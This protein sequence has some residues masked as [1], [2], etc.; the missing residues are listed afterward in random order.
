[1]ESDLPWFHAAVRQRLAADV[2]FMESCQQRLTE[3][4][5]Q[6]S[7]VTIPYAT[8][9]FPAS[10]G[11]MGGGGYTP[12]VQVD[13]WCPD[14]GYGNEEA[15]VVVWRIASRAKRV[16]EHAQNVSFQTMHWSAK[17]IDLMPLPKDVSRGDANPLV[18][19]MTR[20]VLKIHNI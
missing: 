3:H 6:P 4:A 9:Q 14:D 20:A 1:M 17:P 7:D 12:L 2:D 11:A 13:G 18:R 16:L 5:N 8:I 10:I 19:A 15:S